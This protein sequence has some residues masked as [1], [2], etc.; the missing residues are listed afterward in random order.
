MKIPKRESDGFLILQ[1]PEPIHKIRKSAANAWSRRVML[2]VH[3]KKEEMNDK[4]P[5]TVFWKGVSWSP[6]TSKIRAMVL[7]KSRQDHCLR[8]SRTG[9]CVS[10][11]KSVSSSRSGNLRGAEIRSS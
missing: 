11:L 10:K 2:Q 7:K 9:T 5:G 6:H 8:W 3:L 1:G 4:R